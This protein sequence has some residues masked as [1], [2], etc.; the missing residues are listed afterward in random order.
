MVMSGRGRNYFLLQV[1]LNC[2]TEG[3]ISAVPTYFLEQIIWL[4]KKVKNI[5]T[6]LRKK[7]SKKEKNKS[8]NWF[9]IIIS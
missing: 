3:F 2:I 8:Y 1:F 7:V 6:Q 4:I 9:I 5:K